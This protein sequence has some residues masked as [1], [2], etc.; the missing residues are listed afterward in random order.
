M[1]EKLEIMMGELMQLE[2]SHSEWLI[3]RQ[4]KQRIEA[5]ELLLTPVN[6]I[7]NDWLTP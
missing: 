4:L 6:N 3:K 5:I 7:K 2:E 1:R